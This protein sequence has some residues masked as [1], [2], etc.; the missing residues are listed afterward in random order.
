MSKGICNVVDTIE[1]TA[2]DVGKKLPLDKLLKQRC[3]CLCVVPRILMSQLQ[4]DRPTD[5]Q[6]DRHC[7]L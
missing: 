1:W 3:S 7:V 2:V 6:T 5:K 4:T